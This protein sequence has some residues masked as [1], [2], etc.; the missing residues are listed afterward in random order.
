MAKIYLKIDPIQNTILPNLKDGINN[1]VPAIYY[2][3]AAHI[4]TSFKYRNQLIQMKN[5]LYNVK[6]ILTS[7]QEHL[8]KSIAKFSRLSD[9]L[10]K[11]VSVIPNPEITKKNK[12]Y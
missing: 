2:M 7:E 5:D 6:N 4:P 12:K 3:D 1:L 8:I 11:I 9:E 10:T